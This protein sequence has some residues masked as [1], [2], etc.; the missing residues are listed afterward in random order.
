[1]FVLADK[2]ILC[3][4]CGTLVGLAYT[5][6]ALPEFKKHR[7]FVLKDDL[8]VVGID[9]RFYCNEECKRKAQV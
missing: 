5:T 7:R 1:M 8:V 4:S 6:T 3:G 2:Q 9:E